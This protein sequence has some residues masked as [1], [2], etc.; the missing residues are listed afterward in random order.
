MSSTRDHPRTCAGSTAWPRRR[1]SV[2][3]V[4]RR[5]IGLVLVASVLLGAVAGAVWAVW[6]SDLLVVREVRVAGEQRLSADEVRT[7]AAVPGGVPMA[8]LDT[9]AIRARVAGLREVAGVEINRRLPG[10]VEVIVAER[11]PVAAVPRSNGGFSLVDRNGVSFA[12]V[13]R[14]GGLPLIEVDDAA[15]APQT[16]QAGL[17]VVVALPPQLAR[18]VQAVAADGPYEVRLELVD[19]GSVVWGGPEDGDRKAQVLRA[20]LPL[21][22]AVYDVSAPERPTT[23]LD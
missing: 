8:R 13:R 9:D 5:L 12:T 16:L 6:W 1:T 21:D 19:G 22:A 15:P 10:T 2:W 18:Q 14:P 3:R 20:L 23:R 7:A 17:A 11:Q 4:R